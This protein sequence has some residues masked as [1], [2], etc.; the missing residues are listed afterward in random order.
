MTV[1]K[2]NFLLNGPQ[3]QG[4]CVN[5][6]VPQF[7]TC[8]WVTLWDIALKGFM[9]ALAPGE[10]SGGGGPGP[11]PVLCQ[12]L[13]AQGCLGRVWATCPELIAPWAGLKGHLGASPAPL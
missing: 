2:A 11:P 8:K 9:L 5:S 10:L 1:F 12:P 4:K 6:S 13:C 7:P 3:A